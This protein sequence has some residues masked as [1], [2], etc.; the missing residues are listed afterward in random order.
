VPVTSAP[1]RVLLVH[2]LWMPGA[3]MRRLAARLAPQGFAP[4]V[5]AYSSIVGGTDLAS[6]RLRAIL[7]RGDADVIAHSLGGLITLQTLRAHPALAVRRVV[8]L[9][10]PLR[11]SAAAHGLGQ[12]PGGEALLGRSGALLRSGVGRWDG[13]AQ[14]GMIAGSAPLGLGRVL[15]RFRE[16]ND[17]TVAVAE[18]RLEGLADHLLLPVSH[19]GLVYSAAVAEAAVAFL[20]EGRFPSTRSGVSAR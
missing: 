1:R 12:L 11:G 9:G 13:S 10:S 3:V 4:E 16:P 19:T 15:G 6:S 18:T 5:F 14:V 7:A 2:G 8:C 17:G 20:R